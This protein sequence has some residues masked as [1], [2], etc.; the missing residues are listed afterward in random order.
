MGKSIVTLH[1]L[2]KLNSNNL[3]LK[4]LSPYRYLSVNA[5]LTFCWQ[6]DDGPLFSHNSA[7]VI[8]SR[9]QRF[10]NPCIIFKN[11]FGLI[12]MGIKWQL[13][14]YD[15]KEVDIGHESAIYTDSMS[16]M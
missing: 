9:D 5:V 1:K 14:F 2:K 15:W 3:L 12:P 11:F 4:E 7:K 13:L 8:S 6:T 16:L 10:L